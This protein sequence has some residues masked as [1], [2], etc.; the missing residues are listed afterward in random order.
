M[1]LFKSFNKYKKRL[2]IIDENYADLSYQQVL[3]ETNKIK[4][5]NKEKISYINSIRKF[6]RLITCLYILHS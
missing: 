2:A 4:K 5:K 1:R 6:P 3:S